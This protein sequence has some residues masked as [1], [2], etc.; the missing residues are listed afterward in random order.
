M[1]TNAWTI[2]AGTKVRTIYGETAE[3]VTDWFNWECSVTVRTASGRTERYHPTKVFIG[4]SSLPY[5]P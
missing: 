5:R 1:N 3:L 4:G 2:T